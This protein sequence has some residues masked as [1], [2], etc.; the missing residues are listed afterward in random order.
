MSSMGISF[1]NNKEQQ[2][3]VRLIYE[4][5]HP[6]IF[7]TGKAGTGKTFATLAAALQL[8]GEKR[9][10][11]IIYARNPVSVGEDMGYLPGT[12]DEK[13]SPF[14]GPLM[15][16]LEAIHRISPDHPNIA[17]MRAKIE[18]VPIA[19]LRGRSFEDTIVIIDEAQNL[20]LTALKTILTRIGNF[21]K[22]ILLGST[23]QIDDYRQ[24][25]KPE[26][27]FT[28]VMK[29]LADRNYTAVIELV[30]SMRSDICAD[31]DTLLEELEY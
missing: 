24:R 26:C 8:V 9:Y 3:L 7:C 21:C 23:N 22:V 12:A 28:R 14:M 27:D 20:D 30:D 29:K 10:S 31:V 5:G 17:N 2:E 4:K 19:F 25:K 18:T 1:K 6:I 13:Y 16:N 15:D 11:K